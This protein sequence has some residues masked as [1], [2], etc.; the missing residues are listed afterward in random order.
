[1]ELPRIYHILAYFPH[2]PTSRRA[3]IEPKTE[4]KNHSSIASKQVFPFHPPMPR[5]WLYEILIVMLL[6]SIGTDNVISSITANRDSLYHRAGRCEP[7]KR[8]DGDDIGAFC[9]TSKPRRGTVV[10]SLPLSNG[11][12]PRAEVHK[13]CRKYVVH[14]RIV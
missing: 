2:T 9:P 12:E 5:E 1:M 14:F 11:F 13:F 6:R 10:K 3:K 4:K 8:S 7:Y